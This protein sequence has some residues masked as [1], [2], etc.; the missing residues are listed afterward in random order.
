MKK[1]TDLLCHNDFMCVSLDAWII[2]APET[3]CKMAAD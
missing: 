3:I 2:R 1:T